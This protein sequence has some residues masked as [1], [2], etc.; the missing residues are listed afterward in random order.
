MTF[1]ASTASRHPDADTIPVAIERSD[2]I[3]AA[4]GLLLLA[5]Q[6]RRDAAS[7]RS[8]GPNMALYRAGQRAAAEVYEA[9][10]RRVQAAADAAL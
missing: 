3:D 10:A 9:A 1:T 2:A 4:A 5:R 6:A 8:A 7:R